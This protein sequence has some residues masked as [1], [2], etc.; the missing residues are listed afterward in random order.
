MGT[1]L[2]CVCVWWWWGGKYERQARQLACVPHCFGHRQ[3]MA[4]LCIATPLQPF[5]CR[6]TAALTI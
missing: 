2:W 6:S 5:L 3:A 1:L 4:A